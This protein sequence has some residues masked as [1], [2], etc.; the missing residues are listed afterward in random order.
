MDIIGEDEFHVGVVEELLQE[1]WKLMCLHTNVE[2]SSVIVNCTMV[3]IC[4]NN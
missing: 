4:N 2:H 3:S 1:L